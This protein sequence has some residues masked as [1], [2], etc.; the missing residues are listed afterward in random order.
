M[1]ELT[2]PFVRP[3]VAA[4]VLFLDE[5]ERV[6][7]VVPSYKDYLDIPGGYVEPGE[8]PRAAAQRE[9]HEEL[10]IKP[11]VGRLLVADWWHVSTD[12]LGGPKL[13]FVFDGGHLPPS[14]L[15]VI[16]VDG[17]EVTGFKFHAVPEL[18]AITVP[19]LAN[20]IEHAV[21][22]HQDGSTKYLEDGNP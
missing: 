4:G 19:R 17:A 9:V 6:L 1:N 7:L 18:A 5:E 13:L 16:A 14:Q 15:D 11:P 21:A 12:G 10:G 22:A 8:S 20:R 3:R 2:A